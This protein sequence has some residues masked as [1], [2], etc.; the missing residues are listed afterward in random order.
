VPCEYQFPSAVPDDERAR[1][2]SF[3]IEDLSKLMNGDI[4]GRSSRCLVS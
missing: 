4:L 3:V 2:V 1:E